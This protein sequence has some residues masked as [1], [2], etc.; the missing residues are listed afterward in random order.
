M[1][2]YVIKGFIK[3]N[4]MAYVK[5]FVP[6]ICYKV[7]VNVSYD[8]QW[9]VFYRFCFTMIEIKYHESL[10]YYTSFRFAHSL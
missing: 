2:P 1:N 3:F 5:F 10:N 4:Y 9:I 8:S 7:L 6:F